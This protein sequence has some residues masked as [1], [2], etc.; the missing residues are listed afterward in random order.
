MSSFCAHVDQGVLRTALKGLSRTKDSREG[1]WASILAEG[2]QLCLDLSIRTVCVPF[3]GD[4][5]VAVHVPFAFF[6][7]LAAHLPDMEFVELLVADGQLTVG[8]LSIN[9]WL[10]TRPKVG[11]R[12]VRLPFP[13]QQLSLFW[14]PADRAAKREQGTPCA[15]VLSTE[16]RIDAAFNILAP[17]G[18]TRRQLRDL[19]DPQI[20]LFDSGP[21]KDE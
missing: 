12:N 18:V 15:D 2:S 13:Q 6:R 8:H 4:W 1:R 19:I 9:C 20:H 5:P 10:K 7:R 3:R 17:L 11:A 16:S 14:S 21:Q